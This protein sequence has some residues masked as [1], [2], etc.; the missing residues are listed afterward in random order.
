LLP[1]TSHA[2]SK[3]RVSAVERLQGDVSKTVQDVDL[4]G[5]RRFSS[6]S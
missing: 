3:D 1:Q 5:A 4:R 6:L 2:Q